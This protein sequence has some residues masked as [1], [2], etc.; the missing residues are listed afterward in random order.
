MQHVSPLPGSVIKLI[1]YH[2]TLLIELGSSK[3]LLGAMKKHDLLSSL[4]NNQIV[5]T[6]N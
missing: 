6:S 4:Q 5:K 2:H 1:C 3:S